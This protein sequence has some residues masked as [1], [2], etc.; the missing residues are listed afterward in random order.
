[1]TFHGDDPRAKRQL[2]DDD[3]LVDTVIPGHYGDGHGYGSGSPDL[4]SGDSDFGSAVPTYGDVYGDAAIAGYSSTY[5]GSGGVEKVGTHYQFNVPTEQGT[6]WTWTWGEQ[7]GHHTYLS[8][9]LGSGSGVPALTTTTAGP[10][11]QPVTTNAPSAGTTT[12]LSP[13]STTTTAPEEYMRLPRLFDMFKM[14]SSTG[15]LIE[16]VNIT[17]YQQHNSTHARMRAVGDDATA[18]LVVNWLVNITSGR[19]V[20]ALF[21]DG[22]R[23]YGTSDSVG[24]IHWMSTG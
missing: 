20:S 15:E 9:S 22:S 24:D 14:E 10:G 4:G 17:S 13:G 12:T 6:T 8:Q 16:H 7:T 5:L 11:G 2:H 23:S 19:A 3:V 18:G 21:P 1:M